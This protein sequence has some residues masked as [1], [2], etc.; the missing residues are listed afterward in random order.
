VLRVI[1]VDD[2]APARRYLRRL[3]DARTDVRVVG[4]AATRDAATGLVQREMPDAM[5]LDVDLVQGSGFD[6]LRGLGRAPAVAFVTAHADHAA[7]AFDV[8]AVDYLL[9]PVSAQRLDDT[10]ARL[11]QAKAA[12][13]TEACLVVRGRHGTR[14]IRA[15]TVAAAV[16]Q[17]DYVR[18]HCA[19][20]PAELVHSTLTG[21]APRLPAPPF[22][23]ISRSVI[24][25]LDHVDALAGNGGGRGEVRFRHAAVPLELGM[26]AFLRLRRALAARGA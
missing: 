16:A 26:T 20:G 9:K 13:S 12:A 3:L 5:F 21:L 6:L 15:A 14:Q 4:E 23:R 10:L 18:L 19:D 2:E 22:L 11:H 17:G 25:N 8:A 7:R 24:V 1:I